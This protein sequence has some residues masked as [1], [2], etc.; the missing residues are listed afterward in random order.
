MC[1]LLHV[2]GGTILPSE[3]FSQDCTKAG[4]MLRGSEK[5]LASESAPSSWISALPPDATLNCLLYNSAYEASFPRMEGT[6]FLPV[7]GKQILSL[8]ERYGLRYVDFF[9]ASLCFSLSIFQQSRHS[10]NACN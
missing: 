6:L 2:V 8:G 9:Q 3:T 4:E 10:I 1:E 5:K 7:E